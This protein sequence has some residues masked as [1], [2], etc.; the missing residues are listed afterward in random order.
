[1]FVFSDAFGN[2]PPGKTGRRETEKLRLQSDCKQEIAPRDS[3]ALPARSLPLCGQARHPFEG[4]Q[5]NL[6]DIV[7]DCCELLRVLCE[8]WLQ[9]RW[10]QRTRP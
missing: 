9:W 4:A 6:Q 8:R 1:M 2:W 7:A 3:R 10:R 5:R